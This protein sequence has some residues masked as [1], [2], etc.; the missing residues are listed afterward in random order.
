VAAAWL[1]RLFP[2]SYW[3]HMARDIERR[4]RRGNAGRVQETR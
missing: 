4:V 2:V 1:Q 3:R